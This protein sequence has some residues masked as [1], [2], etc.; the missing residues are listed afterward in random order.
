MGSPAMSASGFP[1]KRVEAIRAGIRT[2]GFI[3]NCP[4]ILDLCD[5]SPQ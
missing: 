3:G 1:G 2:I 5:A 4:E